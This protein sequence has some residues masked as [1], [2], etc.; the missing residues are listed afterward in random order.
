MIENEYRHPS[1]I[2]SDGQEP[3]H[4]LPW[5]RAP[6]MGWDKQAGDGLSGFMAK[7]PRNGLFSAAK[8]HQ[9]M[10]LGLPGPK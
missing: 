6:G 9:T 2:G 1:S 5:L 10:P 4:S 7:K 3:K 8:G